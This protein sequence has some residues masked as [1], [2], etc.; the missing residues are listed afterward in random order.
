QQV[1]A[2][3]PLNATSRARTLLDALKL[4]ADRVAEIGT[5]PK[6]R[7]LE[8]MAATAPVIG[9]GS[10]YFGPVLD[11]RTLQQHPF[12]PQAPSISAHIP[13]MIGKTHEERSLLSGGAA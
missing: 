2:S 11:E 6:A 12:Y 10:L 4:P 9:T 8:A 5:L 7:I 13:M 1:T 3:G